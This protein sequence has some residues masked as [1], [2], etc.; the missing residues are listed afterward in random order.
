MV[1]VRIYRHVVMGVFVH[2]V[3][4]VKITEKHRKTMAFVRAA[5]AIAYY[6]PV[7]AV[8]F[9]DQLDYI[10]VKH[11]D[12]KKDMDAQVTSVQHGVAHLAV[13]VKKHEKFTVE[14]KLEHII[15]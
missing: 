12:L 15:E 9:I 6:V 11:M 2:L 8:S 14:V 3:Y 13:F 1:A 4:L 5:V 7:V 10:F